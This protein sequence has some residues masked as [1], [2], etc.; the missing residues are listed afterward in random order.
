[1]KVFV[2]NM[3]GEPLMPCSPRKA[4]VLLRDGK[5]K[6]LRRNPFTIQLEY[7]SSGY[8]QKLTL[9]VDTGHGEVGLS[10]VSE[11]QE[12]FSAVATMRNDI[13]DLMTTRRMYRRNKRNRLRYREPRFL[14]RSASTR[15][16]RLAPS[17]QWKVDA[18]VR[19]INKLKSVLPITKLVLETG[20]F[21]PHKLLNPE[22]TNEQYQ[23]GVQYG[24]E[25]VKAYILSRDGYKCQCGKNGCSDELQVHHII[26]RSD[27]GSDRPDNLITLC[28][29][30]HKTLHDGKWSLS[31]K[32][33]QS[34]KSAT[35]MNVIRTRLLELFPEAIETFGYVTKANAYHFGIKKSHS[36][37]AFVISG[38]SDQE[39]VT[40]FKISFKRKN[41]RSLQKNR[42]GFAPS[43]RR[44]R[45]KIQPKDLVAWDGKIHVAQGMQ[46]RGAYLKFTDGFKSFVKSIKKIDLLYHQ[47][48]LMF[49]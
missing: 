14:N 34:L 11:T 2:L 17:V 18:H 27:G 5:A 16:G 48:G 22:I 39:R 1:M 44:Q 12:V 49:A 37:D 30:H 46:N 13:S 43:I 36:N 28:K 6:V 25:N 29:K 31:V 10:V 42:K 9:G 4:K 8:R 45:Y 23:Q 19:L 7:G 47:R 15:K 21:D 41:N 20:K 3:H 40:P 26:F 24:F 38:G 33:H 35:T 32:K